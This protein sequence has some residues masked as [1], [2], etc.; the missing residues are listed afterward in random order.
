MPMR[1]FYNASFIPNNLKINLLHTV[2]S[3]WLPTVG[4]NGCRTQFFAVRSD[5]REQMIWCERIIG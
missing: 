5:S 3:D 2:R 1:F 4:S